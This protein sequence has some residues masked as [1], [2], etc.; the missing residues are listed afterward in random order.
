MVENTS[1]DENSGDD[2]RRLLNRI[3]VLQNRCDLD[4][5]LF[6]ARHWR[7]LISS[8]QLARLLG[9]PLKEIARSRD[10]L[11]AAGLLTRAQDPTRPERMYLLD[12]EC[13]AT[14]PLAAIVALASTPGGRS[15]LRRA[16]TSGSPGTN[17]GARAGRESPDPREARPPRDGPG[18]A[19]T[20]SR[21]RRSTEQPERT[22]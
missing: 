4:L 12:P 9:Y 21:E 14:G 13:M 2:A 6:F 22:Q 3:P 5:P 19:R 7:A 20:P 18:P 1:G 8:D 16:L 15:S 10:V 11:V 17:D